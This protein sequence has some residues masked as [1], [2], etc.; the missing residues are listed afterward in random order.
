[1]IVYYQTKRKNYNLSDII[2]ILFNLIYLFQIFKAEINDCPKEKPI[3]ISGECKLQYCSKDKFASKECIINN[4]II[5]TQWLNNFIFIGDQSFRYINFATYS[6][7]DMIIGT[8]SFP[9]KP[10]RMFYGLKQNGRPFFKNRTNN[11]ETPYYSIMFTGENY[12]LTESKGIIIKSSDTYKEYFLCV[13]RYDNNVELFDFENDEI[14]YKPLYNFTENNIIY[15]K[16]HTFFPLTNS[17]SNSD[18]YYIFGFLSW[19]TN[20]NR[21]YLQKHIFNSI[22]NFKNISTYTSIGVNETNSYGYQINCYQTVK[23][24]ICCFYL[25][26]E[27]ITILYNFVK[28]KSDFSDKVSISLPSNVYNNESFCK[29]IHLKDEIGIFV[30][31]INDTDTNILYPSII[32]KEFNIE[33]NQFENYLSEEIILSKYHF[34]NY[35]LLNDIIK[36]N[37]KKFVFIATIEDKETLYIVV[38]NLFVNNKYKIRYYSLKLFALYHYKILFDLDLYIYKNFISIGLSFCPIANC[39]SDENEHYSGLIIFSYPNS[40]DEII[41][42]DEFLFNNNININDFEIDLKNKLNIENNLFGYIFSS[43]SIVDLIGCDGYKLYSSID[44]TKEIGK[45]VILLHNEN[46][47]LLYTNYETSNIYP[48]VNCTIQYYFNATEP[49]LDTYNNYTEYNEGSDEDVLFEK[50]EYAGR[51]IYYYIILNNEL[52]KR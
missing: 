7:G 47:K 37:E 1:M 6:N 12:R 42:I 50:G 9:Q 3:L 31:Y 17:N 52:N 28:Y 34:L 19:F 24:L 5:K 13:S 30:Y 25:T 11:E 39:S 27:N 2:F 10:K 33:K 32:L 35:L 51:L 36:I 15:S 29:C 43:I 20:D 21:V 26:Q 14:F 48:T 44:E 4:E 23:G 18:Y 8:T 45:N 38:I 40:T 46:I 22:S 16:V 49:D 41:Y